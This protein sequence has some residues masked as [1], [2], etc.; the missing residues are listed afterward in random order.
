MRGYTPVDVTSKIGPTQPPATA[1]EGQ[2]GR[3]WEPPGPPQLTSEQQENYDVLPGSQPGQYS[4][5]QKPKPKHRVG[6]TR[7]IKS[8]NQV[9]TQVLTK[10]KGWV[11]R[12]TSPRWD[13]DEGPPGTISFTNKEGT[14]SVTVKNTPANVKKFKAAGWEE[15][16]PTTQAGKD[17]MLSQD[18][19][20]ENVMK[21][22]KISDIDSMDPSTRSKVT[23]VSVR[24][25]ELIDGGMKMSRAMQQAISEVE[26]QHTALESIPRA[27]TGV[28]NN[29]D[30]TRQA[31]QN[32]LNQ[33]SPGEIHERLEEQGWEPEEIKQ[34][35]GD[36]LGNSESS[37][38]EI[39][40]DLPSGL[41]ED[42]VS[43]NMR[44]YGKS[45]REVIEQY[46]SLKGLK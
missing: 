36:L 6:D 46:K 10:E 17:P 27:N 18:R 1:V 5:V 30:E 15:G 35:F 29:V 24:A 16:K 32:A 11:D 8:G 20:F 31:V 42:D 25:Q 34:H 21:L 28:F 7:E 19:V 14:R 39:N 37:P 40:P 12:Y 38:L 45:R 44:K 13:D 33:V 26:G 3:L 9:V 43:F 41:S 4:V 2:F 22:Y 23:Q